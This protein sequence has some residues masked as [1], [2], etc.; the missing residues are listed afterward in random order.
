MSTTAPDAVKRLVDRFD[1]DR[2]VFLSPDYKEEQLRAEFL[3]GPRPTIRHSDFGVCT[4]PGPFF[5]AL[6]WDGFF[7]DAAL[8]LCLTSRGQGNRVPETPGESSWTAALAAALEARVCACS[9]MQLLKRLKS[10]PRL[11]DWD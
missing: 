9:T 10:S 8:V 2:K 4:F 5:T 11:S 6:G 3:N 1:R 7:G